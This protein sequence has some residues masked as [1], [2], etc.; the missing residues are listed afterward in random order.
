MDGY[1][2][3]RSIR[4]DPELQGTYLVALSGY[5]LA[6]DAQRAMESGFDRHLA[7]PPSIEDLERILAEVPSSRPPPESTPKA[8]A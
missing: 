1:E 2:V 5:A 6:S 7:N 3:A 4:A 8:G